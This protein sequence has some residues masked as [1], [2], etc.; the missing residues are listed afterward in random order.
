MRKSRAP[1]FASQRLDLPGRLL[2]AAAASGNPSGTGCD[3]ACESSP[4]DR[5]GGALGMT[6][7]PAITAAAAIFVVAVGVSVAVTT[8]AVTAIA[9]VVGEGGDG[10]GEAGD[11]DERHYRLCHSD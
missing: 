7:A 1:I 11:G 5:P 3:Q 6:G 10:E 9:V 4:G 2:R 8:A